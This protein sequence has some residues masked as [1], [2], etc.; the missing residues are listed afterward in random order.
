MLLDRGGSVA[1]DGVNDAMFCEACG[2]HR[3]QLG[4]AGKTMLRCQDCGRATCANCWNQVARACLSC[5][6]FTLLNV[7]PADVGPFLVSARAIPTMSVI[8]GVVE[9]VP[10]PDPTASCR[11][12]DRSGRARLGRVR[13]GRVIRATIIGSALA[14]SVAAVV[15]AGV[16]RMTP[17]APAHGQSTGRPDATATQGPS[18]SV[19][20]RPTQTP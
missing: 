7:A 17:G 14:I 12:S 8:P 6:A 19:T 1:N 11:R 10:V 18:S 16:I 3:D 20:A 13:L 9:V 4:A 5:R 2:A 15:F